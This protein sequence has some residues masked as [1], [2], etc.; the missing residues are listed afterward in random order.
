MAVPVFWVTPHLFTDEKYSTENTVDNT[1]WLKIR[2]V[3]YTFFMVACIHCRQ[4]DPEDFIF[5]R[6][7]SRLGPKY[8][9]HVSP[10]DSNPYKNPPRGECLIFLTC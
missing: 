9:V 4:K 10:Y 6:T 2:L 1:L 8:Q 7:A 3:C 5:P